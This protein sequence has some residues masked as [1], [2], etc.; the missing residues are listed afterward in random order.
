[1]D[2]D[3]DRML[4]VGQDESDKG[5]VDLN[6]SDILDAICIADPAFDVPSVSGMPRPAHAAPAMPAVPAAPAAPTMPAHGH[7]AALAPAAAPTV[8]IVE[9]PASKALRFRYECEGRSAGSIP[10]VNSTSERKTYPTIEISGCNGNAIVVVSC[11]TKDHPYKPHPHNLVGRERCERGVCTVKAEL[12]G[13]STLVSF[14]NLGIQ[15]VK[16]KDV[17]AALR[18]REELRVD[19]FKTG[20][21]HRA[22]PQ[23]IDLNAVRL[24]FQV[25]VTGERGKVRLALAPVVSDVIY[26]KKAMSDLHIARVSHCAGPAGGRMTMI[27]LCEKVTGQDTAVVFFEKAN[28]EVVWEAAATNV[29]VHKQ[30]AIAFDIPPYRDPAPHDN[31]KVYL[32]LK[33]VTDNA[34]SNAVDFEYTATPDVVNSKRKK[35]LSPF[36]QNITFKMDVGGQ[37]KTEPRES[38][39]YVRSPAQHAYPPYE[40][41]WGMEMPQQLG[42]AGPSPGAQYHAQGM[43]WMEQSY[44]Q[45]APQLQPHSPGVQSP[46]SPAMPHH[47][48]ALPHHSPAMGHV[49]PGMGQMSPAMGHVSPVMGHVSPG[50]GHVSPGMG[51]VSPGMGHVSPGMGQ[52]SPGMGQ[53]SPAMGHVSPGMGHVSP[54]LN[55]GQGQYMQNMGQQALI[56]ELEATSTSTPSLSKLLEVQ[57]QAEGEE[58]RLSSDLSFPMCGADLSDSL[59]DLSTK[60]LLSNADWPPHGG[61]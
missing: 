43:S 7:P 14:S 34:R 28:E 27:L 19:P 60:D 31:V 26:D 18:T 47:H 56:Q 49:S 2:N 21:S 32:Q 17:D 3:G 38:P 44:L 58:M 12:S 50:M 24:C 53:V 48:L 35:P 20:F 52:M 55:H 61:G 41:Q 36:A 54:Q 37:I 40:Q 15:C 16:R 46:L 10:G 5:P 59:R 22:Q 25:F 39:S 1:M 4:V 30:A 51:H 9:Q 42:V 33:R 23:S 11:V 13:D 45:V 8:R 6:I 29:H 57:G